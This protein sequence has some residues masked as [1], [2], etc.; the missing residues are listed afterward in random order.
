MHSQLFFRWVS[1]LLVAG[2]V[3]L[4]GALDVPAV[5]A[6]EMRAETA[7]TRPDD[8]SPP[9]VSQA[10]SDPNQMTMANPGSIYEQ[11]ERDRES[12]DHLFQ[13]PGADLVTNPWSDFRAYLDEKFGFRPAFSFTHVYQFASD[14]VGR[15]DDASA[16]ELNL[17]ATW[18]VFGRKT[19][20]PT[21]VGF[22]FLYSH[23]LGTNLPSDALFT[24]V[25]SIYP[26]TIAFGNV[27]PSVGQLWLQQVINDRFGFRIGK[28]YPLDAY[29]FFP[30]KNF[31]MD[32]V[33]GVQSANLVIP[34]PD[35]GLGGFVEYRP[36]PEIYVRFG[37]HDADADTEK[38]GFSSLFNHGYLFKIFEVGIDPGF[39][40]RIPGRA[41]F[42]DIHVSFWQQDKRSND[43]I[44]K[45]WGFLIS[46]SQRFGRF[47]PFLRYGYSDSGRFGPTPMSHVVNLGV[48]IDTFAQR[49]DR[50]GIG[51]SWSHPADGDLDDQGALDLFYRAEVTPQIAVTPTLQLILNPALN[52]SQ[53]AVWVLGVRSRFNF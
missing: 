50:I 18:T 1:L 11:F 5:M 13:I 37:I 20:S 31:R 2:V 45:G 32:F 43:N 23:K 26:T 52:P 51:M 24:Q 22:E 41:P 42:G 46:G 7:A 14:S 53:D 10:A 39:M 49:N 15:D 4:T 19:A 38:V 44:D 30:L 25:G 34:L 12:K 40:E 21:M 36:E 35:R 48:A 27:D 17:N 9:A 16:Y 33:D 47:M 29:D 3:S 6:D 8:E 28:Y